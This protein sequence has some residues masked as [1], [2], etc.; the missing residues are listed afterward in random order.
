MTRFSYLYYITAYCFL[1]SAPP[2]VAAQEN[3][4]REESHKNKPSA[5]KSEIQAKPLGTLILNFNYA[6]E[7]PGGD[8]GKLFGPNSAAG[9]QCEYMDKSGYFLGLGGDFLFGDNLKVDVLRNLRTSQ[10]II[11]GDDNDA[12]DVSLGERG[13]YFNGYVGKLFKLKETPKAMQGLR[14]SFGVGFLEHN[15]RIS[16]NRGNASQVAG[17]Y[18]NGYDR[19]TNG[20][21]MDQ[22]VGY[23]YMSADHTINF[24]IGLDITEGFTKNRRLFNFD[25]MQ[26]DVNPH[27]DL[28]SGLRMGWV[29]PI[30]RYYKA[31]EIE[32]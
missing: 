7:I 29:L 6:V 1:F 30:H 13:V 9:M 32:Y 10:G 12:A 17:I 24:Y 22:F 19:L 28:L 3:N 31:N 25:T 8:M 11:L 27:F 2:P 23:Q 15:V 16:D 20:I 26:P 5:V 14:L 18:A 4:R 21:G